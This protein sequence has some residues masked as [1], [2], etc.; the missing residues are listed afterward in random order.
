M[1]AGAELLIQTVSNLTGITID[2]YVEISLLG[3]YNLSNSL[4]GVNICL[5]KDVDDPVSGLKMTAGHHKI[6]GTQALQFVRQRHHFP[7][8]ADDGDLNR[9]HRQQ[10]FL[11]SAVDQIISA[12]WLVEPW[13]LNKVVGSVTGALT[14]D[15]D[16]DIVKLAEQMRN[17]A[18][19]NVTFTTMPTDG[20]APEDSDSL[21]VSPSQVRAFFRQ[22]IGADDASPS[23]KPT[24]GDV[25]ARP[26]EDVGEAH[27]VGERVGVEVG[28]SAEGAAGRL[29]QQLRVLT[30]MAALDGLIRAAL[31]RSPADPLLTYY[32]DSTGERVELSG[33]TLGNWVAKTANLLQDDYSVAA[34][35][36]VAV[37]L[38][39][40]W[41]TAAILLATWSVGG[42][43]VPVADGAS[44]AFTTA[45]RLEQ[46]STA[47]DVIALALLPLGR[48]FP[49]PP[50]GTQDFA[51]VVPSQPD[52][53]TAYAPPADDD[54]AV[55]DA[56]GTTTTAGALAAA[57]TER[58]AALGL[59]AGSRILL[60]AGSGGPAEWFAELLVPLAA[61]AS[62]VLCANAD[63]A[64]LPGRA[65]AERVSAT[66]G[67]ELAGLRRLDG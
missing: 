46:A 21:A 14:V 22:V 50:A 41:Q 38:P 7:V 24:Q 10:A 66:L 13:R 29:R 5:K 65:E 11:G 17:L 47:A 40:H 62:L 51:R 60:P 23:P 49:Q 39:A 31:A 52:A 36:R 59:T 35:D 3:F 56:A 55:A 18:A 48:A 16:L 64:A 32:D 42:C 67:V 20:P 4:G 43:A 61:G 25:L 53:F 33:A 34:G 30:P 26:G 58:A 37:L 15:D 45:D 6:K 28:R 57:A 27:P 63:P 12:H 9:I 44:V 19:G 2:H 8:G 54:P 1:Q